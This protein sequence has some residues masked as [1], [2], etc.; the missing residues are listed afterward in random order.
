MAVAA[1]LE[2]QAAYMAAYQASVSGAGFKHMAVAGC[3]S[4][5]GSAGWC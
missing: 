2:V 5:T 4:S 3:S 1:M